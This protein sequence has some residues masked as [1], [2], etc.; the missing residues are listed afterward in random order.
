MYDQ[1]QRNFPIGNSLA[2]IIFDSHNKITTN[3]PQL[4]IHKTLAVILE[5]IRITFYEK[6]PNNCQFCH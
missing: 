6:E 1:L 3:S 5:N 4:I 2:L